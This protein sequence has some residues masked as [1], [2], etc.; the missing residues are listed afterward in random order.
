M[1]PALL[2]RISSGRPELRNRC[3]NASMEAGSIRSNLSSPTRGMPSSD[4]R[5]FSGVRAGSEVSP[6]YDPMIAKLIVWDSDRAAA[7]QRMLRALREFEITGVSTLIP[8][9]QRL[10][11]TEQWA[12]AETCRDLLEDDQWLASITAEP[13]LANGASEPAPS[14]DYTVE[15]TWSTCAL[16]GTGSNTV[17]VNDAFVPEYRTVDPVDVMEGRAPGSSA[18]LSPIF[19][20]SFSSALFSPL[21]S[22]RVSKSTVTQNGVPTSSWRR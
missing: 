8:F 18:N 20:L 10:L 16:R 19:R 11:A 5:A 6:N 22:P 4:A 15:D 13:A 14:T 9:H 17:V 2:I 3:A 12:R 1:M 7:T 21:P